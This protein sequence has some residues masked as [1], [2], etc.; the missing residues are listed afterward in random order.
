MVGA[1]RRKEIV[2][3][4][5]TRADIGVFLFFLASLLIFSLH[6][7][8][9]TKLLSFDGF[10]HI[11]YARLYWERGLFTEFPWMHFSIA[12]EY[13]ADHHFLFHLLLLPFSKL[14]VLKGQQWAGAVFGSLALTSCAFYLR[15]HKV[16]RGWLFAVLLWVCS[17]Y[18]L[19][20]M[21]MTRAMSLA[22]VCF[23]LALLC[24]EKRRYLWLGVVSFAFVWLYQTALLLLPLAVFAVFWRWSSEKVWDWKPLFAVS[25]GLFLGLVLNPFFPDTFPFLWFHLVSGHTLLKVQIGQEWDPITLETMRKL[26]YPA[27]L[28]GLVVPLV[29]LLQTMVRKQQGEM[30][31]WDWWKESGLLWGL[32]WM[33]FGLTLFRAIRFLEYAPAF[34]ILLG[35]RLWP[36]LGLNKPLSTKEPEPAQLSNVHEDHEESPSKQ[37]GERESSEEKLEV[38][39]LFAPRLAK[40]M[41]W[42]SMAALV[43]CF[44][45]G[46]EY[47]R[48]ITA[49]AFIIRPHVVAPSIQWLKKNSPKD[50]IVFSTEWTLFPLLFAYNTHNRYISGLNPH[51][52]QHWNP[53]LHAK[54]RLLCQGKHKSPAKTIVKLFQSRYVYLFRQGRDRRLLR[55]LRKRPGVRKVYKDRYV[56]ILFLPSL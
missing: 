19:F 49:K 43:S 42:L 56:E 41:R 25:A 27:V 47:H 18:F 32:A 13:W 45:V 37:T 10:Y 16:Q 17:D 44:V 11:A 28:L 1:P 33:M 55:Q 2:M 31:R 54:Y 48:S 36:W 34:G 46:A 38:A 50:A 51:F 5:S 7:F 53:T 21:M 30:V 15:V 40:W 24:M 12:R 22:V 6:I 26:A 20:R 39:P 9:Q 14:G 29:L 8:S 23:V 4:A 3:K 52:F 35:A